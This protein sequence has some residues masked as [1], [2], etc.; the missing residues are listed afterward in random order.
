MVIHGDHGEAFLQHEGNFAHTLFAYDE[1]L[2]VPFIVV[3]PGLVSGGLHA[4]QLV[5]LLDTA[6]TIASLVGVEPD[7]AW[8][9]TSA[10]RPDPRV[11][12][13]LADH[14]SVKPRCAP[15]A[16]SS[17]S[18]PTAVARSSSTSSPI[19]PRRAISAARDPQ[20]AARYA[21]EL[22]RWAAG[23]RAT[24]DRAVAAAP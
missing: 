10:L 2:H 12:R 23:Q 1:N 19:P 11:V 16:T 7:P 3:A 6:P 14:T 24:V 20:R 5:S 8:Q 13:A 15:D 9:G 18:T 22:E 21:A 4:R 17:S